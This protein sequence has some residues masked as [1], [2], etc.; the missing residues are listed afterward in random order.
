MEEHFLGRGKRVSFRASPPCLLLEFLVLVVLREPHLRAGPLDALHALHA[1]LAAVL[2]AEQLA[3]GLR[4]VVRELGV[5][6]EVVEDSDEGRVVLLL[7][8]ERAQAQVRVPVV[9]VAAGLGV[10]RGRVPV[11]GTCCGFS[12]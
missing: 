1:A 2:A 9:E 8:A 5:V 12:I 3:L 11:V 10:G 6:Q 7:Q 4:A